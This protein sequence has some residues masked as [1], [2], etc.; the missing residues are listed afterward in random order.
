MSLTKKFG[1]E[2]IKSI[3]TNKDLNI[4]SDIKVALYTSEPNA[5][6][7]GTEVSGGGYS[8]VSV[9]RNT[10]NWSESE[11]NNKSYTQNLVDI[12]FPAAQADWGTIT[13]FALHSAQNG[14]SN[15]VMIGFGALHSSV[16]V[17]SGNGGPIFNSGSLKFYLDGK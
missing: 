6:G 7:G 3:F 16:E 12:K 2:L 13:H 10:T 17:L 11:E 15:Y 1:A 5:D 4:A 9:A 8:R 14:S